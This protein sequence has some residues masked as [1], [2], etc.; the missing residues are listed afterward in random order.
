[1]EISMSLQ[2]HGW[3]VVMIYTT[4]GKK[5]DIPVSF[6]SDAIHEIASKISILDKDVNEVII[7]MQT[8]PGEYRLKISKIS[9][10]FCLFQL[11]EMSDNF[12]TEATEE[13]T[14]LITEEIKTI[15]LL[16][17]IHRELTKMKDLGSEG[18]IKRWNSDFPIN[19]YERLTDMIYKLKQYEANS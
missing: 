11:F 4:E 16:R 17:I 7:T 9:N 19:A 18:F 5:F 2:P 12:S 8:E 1:M 15:R 10:V 3:L 13:G 14:L 6:L